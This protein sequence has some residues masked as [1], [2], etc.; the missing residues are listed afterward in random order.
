MKSSKVLLVLAAALFVVFSIGC[1]ARQTVKPDVT[2][3]PTLQAAV[4]DTTPVPVATA[5]PGMKYVVKK[6]DTL[7]AVSS[8]NKIY[9]DPFQWPL[10][11]KANRDQVADPDLIEV[12][13]ELDVRKDISSTEKEDAIQKAKDTPPYRAHTAPRKT[14][15]LKY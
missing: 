12:G 5:V 11:Y 7:W 9:Q 4:E 14:L 6:G 8:M 13:Q 15:P 3:A 10:L 2:P 1:A